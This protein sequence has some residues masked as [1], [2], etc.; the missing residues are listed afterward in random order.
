MWTIEAM[1][2]PDAYK[3]IVE[4][5]ITYG[6]QVNDTH[7]LHNLI[8]LIERPC[9]QLPRAYPMQSKML[10]HY[11]QQFHDPSPPPG[12][13]YTYGNRLFS[14]DQF[15]AAINK[16]KK[17]INSRQAILH[18][19][20]V[21]IDMNAESVPCLQT[22]HYLVRNNRLHT[23]AY[24]RSNDMG[25]AWVANVNAILSLSKKA[26]DELGVSP[27]SLTTISSSAHIN[28]GEIDY[29]TENFKYYKEPL[30][31]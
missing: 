26:A 19:W 3:Q 4:T 29:I 25:M 14:P 22:I 10:D 2:I 24:F 8:V 21:D 20:R 5:I 16:L 13:S 28:N 15:T 7:E 31:I 23:T 30:S 12:F 17:D 27:G 18:T 6:E 1:H 9:M 11:I